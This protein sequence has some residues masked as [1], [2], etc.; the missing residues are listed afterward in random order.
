MFGFIINSIAI[1]NRTINFTIRIFIFFNNV[2][3]ENATE[4]MWGVKFKFSA[5][6]K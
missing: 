6:F 3:S 2:E 4:Q 1:N 5:S